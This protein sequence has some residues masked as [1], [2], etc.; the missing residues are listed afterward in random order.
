MKTEINDLL[1]KSIEIIIQTI[2]R[3]NVLGAKTRETFDN[4]SGKVTK[5]CNASK[6]AQKLNKKLEDKCTRLRTNKAIAEKR[7][8]IIAEK[9]DAAK[10]LLED[11]EKFKTD[12][13][14]ATSKVNKSDKAKALKI[15]EDAQ[16]ILKDVETEEA[17][18]A[19]AEAKAQAQADAAAKAKAEAVAAAVAAKAKAEAEAKAKA[20]E[21]AK[22]KAEA[23]AKAKAEAEAAAVAAKAKAEQEAAAE[24]KAYAAEAYAAA[25]AAR[26]KTEAD[27]LAA[28]AAEDSVSS[29]KEIQLYNQAKYDI[30]TQIDKEKMDITQKYQIVDNYLEYLQIYVDGYTPD[31]VSNKTRI[32]LLIKD[33]N[34][35]LDYLSSILTNYNNK[36]ASNDQTAYT[37]VTLQRENFKKILEFNA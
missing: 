28:A 32:S 35:I 7:N 12:K 37:A 24:A 8:G 13:I 6:K 23:A 9:I 29:M 3:L 20:E 14:Q 18:E 26:A 31:N 11:V 33:I 22:A 27:A 2:N 17:K 15:L 34:K 36:I 16:Q 5:V 25:A 1:I 30:R 21:A 19:E 4:V 10:K